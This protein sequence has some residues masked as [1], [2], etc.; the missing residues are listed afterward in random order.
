MS[1]SRTLRLRR[2]WALAATALVAGALA[3]VPANPSSADDVPGV[4]QRVFEL[5]RGLDKLCT[6]KSGQTPNVDVRKDV[7]DWSTTDDF[8]GYSDNFLVHTVGKIEVPQDG[9]Y[10]FRLT[11]DDGSKLFID[12]AEVIDHDG[13]HEATPKD[14]D[15]ELTAG[16]HDLRIEY[17]DATNEQVLKLSWRPPG[18]DDFTVVPTD[19]LSTE[20]ATRVTAPGIKQC[21]GDDDSPGDG[22]PLGDVHPDY[23][24][25]DLRPEGFEPDVSGMAWFPDGRLAVL[26]W[27]KDQESKSGKLYVLRNVTGKT[28]AS[29]VK[30]REVAS[31]LREPQGVAIV[32]GKIY[33]AQKHE[34]SRLV[35]ADGDGTYEGTQTVAKLPTSGN[36][37]EFAFGLLHKKGYF[38]L[39]LSVALEKSGA[40][41]DPQPAKNRGTSLRINAKTG[42]IDYVAGGLRTPNGI[43]WGPDGS[44]LVTDNQGDWLPAN[45]LVQIKRGAF[46]NHYTNPGG[47][48]D[49]NPVTQPVLWLPQNEIANSPSTPVVLKKGPFAGQ[50]AIG[51]VT[52]GGLQRAYLEKVGGEY[53][54]AVFRMTQGLE[55]G[56]N[57]V[58]VG[59]DG[60]LYVG[61]I[62][63]EGNWGQPNKLRF[64]LQ[65]IDTNGK[66]VMDIEKMELTRRGFDLTYTKPVSAKTLRDI[67]SAY[68]VEQWRYSPTG[69]Y[70][71]PK[72]DEERLK[73]RKATV[74]K[75][76]KRVRLTID[77][78]K[79]GRVVHV[80]SPR[81]FTSAG[82]QE[83]WSTEAWYT[84]NK[85]PG[86]T[87]PATSKG[88]YESEEAQLSGGAA[89]A[90][91]HTSYSGGGFVAGYGSKGASAKHHVT[92]RKGGKQPVQI[93]YSNGPD[94][95]EGPK[96]L[97]LFVNGEFVKQVTFP[98]TGDWQ[99]WAYVNSKLALRK[100]SN[101]IELRNREAD[102]GHVNLDFVQVGSG[103]DICR[104]AKPSKGYTSL[105]DGTLASLDDWRMAGPGAFA[106]RH[107]CTI[108]TV[109][110][111]GLLWHQDELENYSLKADW[112]LA[113]DDNAG[114][115]VGFPDPGDDP[116]VAVDHGHEIQI[117]ATDE[118]NKTT[119]AIYNFQGAD[120]EAR[121]KA[122]N[123][124]GQWNSY[125]LRVDG[126]RIRVYLNGVLIND[127]TDTDDER[128]VPPS[129]VGLQNHGGDDTAY[130]R[131]IEIKKLEGGR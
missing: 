87:D 114:I 60:A 97:G 122:L 118:D 90:T 68:Q 71:G 125:R 13:L 107:D 106:R 117:D 73:V 58:S 54:G 111:M 39:S 129:F 30:V 89:L 80:R 44:V 35:D 74:N 110:G 124:P 69:S 19:V 23:D 116:W 67:K 2:S 121:D 75:N 108:R 21:E 29:K 1:T 53:Q 64:G 92:V 96:T 33:V 25:T 38:Y 45:K 78:L 18:A 128:M 94:P 37:H 63:W 12:G 3:V 77:G 127:Y 99:T 102:T 100:G 93:R 82:G 70:G 40:S 113:G 8:G 6:L 86:Y 42:K 26:T 83:L 85:L 109:G 55:A 59:P 11:S 52:Y 65:K 123:P 81:P 72:V 130:F 34:L 41:V 126:D 48:F 46:F 47:R 43:G 66:N 14:G 32:K 5:A 27:G 4:T 76:G 16:A 61:G 9:T 10:T 31:G 20:D 17:F 112:K 104:A 15:V 101:T 22:L 91:D 84:L 88:L 49:D 119:G 51:D 57:E 62:G 56:V 50:L 98:S 103:G 131:N 79:P 28:K 105:F 36:F 115:F 7:V 120:L 95:S 24:L